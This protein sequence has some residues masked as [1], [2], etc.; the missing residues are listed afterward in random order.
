MEKPATPGSRRDAV[1]SLWRHR[2]RRLT[3]GLNV[4]L[5]LGLAAAL[6]VMLNALSL[7]WHARWD[8]GARGYFR[9][10]DKT[11][12]LLSGLH[13]TVDVVSFFEQDHELYDDVRSL[14]K[15][16]AYTAETAGHGRLQVT[17]LNPAREL[18]ETRALARRFSVDKPNVI[19]V[20]CA[21]RTKY[22][23]PRALAEYQY[24][25]QDS[26]T[27]SR[28]M[29][30]FLGERAISSAIQSVAEASRPRVL[31]LTG[32]GERSLEDFGEDRGLSRLAAEMRRDNMEL[33]TLLLAA[34][35]EVPRDASAVVIAG[36]ARPLAAAE[37]AMLSR[38]LDRG[39]RLLAL[40]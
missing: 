16:Y 4:A 20:H 33:G 28:R 36:A 10:S 3:T 18:Q 27:A 39:G 32:H 5:S 21:G 31:F 23:E 25:L 12:A 38:Y 8:L 6:V 40:L 9:L 14:L 22:L 17:V 1:R 35:E 19:V 15:E 7:R 29:A 34:G 26:R 13:E 24:S 2:G 37:V 30:A 11:L